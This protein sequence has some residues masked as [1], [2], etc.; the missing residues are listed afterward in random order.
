MAFPLLSKMRRGLNKPVGVIAYRAAQEARLR[1]L[2]HTGGWQRLE[3]RIQRR[4]TEETA[5]QLANIGPNAV[6]HPRGAEMLRTAAQNGVLSKASLLDA[7]DKIARRE[8]SLL[9]ASVP[10]TGDWPWRID[11][12][13]GHEWPKRAWNGFDHYAK[14]DQPYDV[15]YPWELSRLQFLLPL[16]Q[17]AVLDGDAT[18]IDTALTML[19]SWCAE[20]PFA[21]SVNWYPMETSMRTICLVMALDMA[22]AA[23]ATFAQQVPFLVE[24]DR[25]ASLVWRTIEY[26]DVRG[27][28]YTANLA[29]L[30]CAAAALSPISSE[31]RRW[32][33]Y[34]EQ[35][36]EK[37][38]ALQY[39][40]DGVNFEKS[41]PYHRLVTDLF[42]LMIGVMRL[43]SRPVAAEAI[44]RIRK[45]SEFT[46]RYR[47][48]DGA[49]PIV[50]D[51]DD[52]VVFAMDNLAVN[53]HRSTLA[54]AGALFNDGAL[55][56]AGGAQPS[57][58][59]VT[60]KP[61]SS[62][63]EHP[64]SEAW[65]GEGGFAIIQTPNLYLLADVGEVGMNGRGG[66]GHNDLLSFEL[67]LNGHSFVIDSGSYLYT[68][69]LKARERYRGT[70]AHNTV[71]LDGEEIAPLGS[72][73]F[74]ISAA[75][76]PLAPLLSQTPDA[77]NISGGHT[78]YS[79]LSARATVR[80]RWEAS[81]TLPRVGIYD[82]VDT[83]GA[84]DV[85]RSLH[86][87]PDVD[88]QVHDGY[89]KASIKGTNVRMDWQATTRA[90]LTPSDVSF[91]YGRQQATSVLRLR[92][93]ING[94]AEL[95]LNIEV[96]E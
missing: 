24:I 41:L 80:R 86:F 7:A 95:S 3:R 6:F 79:R 43:Q 37:E 72:Q 50:G 35:R 62:A 27:N 30:L 84:H 42:L 58:V 63:A 65:L 18:H 21:N 52:A 88:I 25:N 47:K 73:P 44:D 69:D 31:A 9:G 36:M 12:R 1:L 82:T 77:W 53:D 55:A 46:R 85:T 14:R 54:V 87:H 10:P 40:P 74:R 92:D 39:L 29:A 2:E 13:F 66:H 38:I 83:A 11:W 75:A 76:V 22:R 5:S 4:W 91:G 32:F 23:G 33:A 20:N 89:A 67:A 60:G 8:F 56:A 28:H 45:A 64:P 57:A 70:S 17:A 59:W 61:P 49:T 71:Q 93:N 48:P 16:L 19:S 51:T 81:K 15:K 90:E 96:I 78:G 34:A 94:K 68:G 26:T